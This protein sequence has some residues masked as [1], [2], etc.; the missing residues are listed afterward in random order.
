ME[1]EFEREHQLGELRQQNLA[2]TQEQINA[3]KR[4]HQEQLEQAR[5]Q[6]EAESALLEEA[7]VQWELAPELER[8]QR[9]A[10]HDAGGAGGA[11]G[12]G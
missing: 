9:E 1:K 6:R 8:I 12:G 10:E 11:W 3:L 7:R 5:S 2:E 4:A